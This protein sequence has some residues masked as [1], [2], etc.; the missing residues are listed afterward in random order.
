MNAQTGNLPASVRQRLLT[1]PKARR[2]DFQRVL[3]QYALERLLYRL[4]RSQYADRFIPKGALLFTLWTL[5]PHR[6]TRDLDLLA[7]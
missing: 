5:E 6:R 2:E 7:Q 3:V 1:L 4:S